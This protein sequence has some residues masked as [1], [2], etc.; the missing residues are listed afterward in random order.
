MAKKRKG[1][2]RVIDNNINDPISLAEA[3][4]LLG[5]HKTNNTL[6]R[7]V[8]SGKFPCMIKLNEETGRDTM[9][10][11]KEGVME[12]YVTGGM[13]NKDEDNNNRERDE[14]D[15]SVGEEK[16]EIPSYLEGMAI[17]AEGIIDFL[18]DMDTGKFCKTMMKS[19]EK[20]LDSLSKM[21]NK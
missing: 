18:D 13:Y 19:M 11:S 7:L 1:D 2:K 4:T 3:N 12:Y 15:C 5:K 14:N 6:Y 9:Y 20:S 8:I 21:Y 17:L 10:V 16:S